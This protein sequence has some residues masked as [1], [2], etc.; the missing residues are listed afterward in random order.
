[1]CYID[2]YFVGE[3]HIQF[4]KEKAGEHFEGLDMLTKLL[5]PKGKTTAQAP[6]IQVIGML[7]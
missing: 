4:P 5:A 7:I 3:F 1:M 6:L 2:N